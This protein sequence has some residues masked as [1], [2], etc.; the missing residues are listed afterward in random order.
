MKK[1]SKLGTATFGGGCFWGIE[2]TFR[3]T[4][5]VIDTAV[6]YMGGSTKNPTYDDVCTDE[7]GHVEVVQITFDPSKITYNQLLDVFWKS[8]DL[9]QVN[10]QGP[11]VDSQ[12]RSVIFF[13][14]KEQEEQAKNS[15]LAIEKSDRFKKAIATVILPAQRF[16][17]AEECHQKYL[18]K[19]GVKTCHL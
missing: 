19:K 8:H 18:M 1:S 10:R 7:T 16:Y 5:G 2:E 6:G 3:T 13:H 15:K 9:T 17:K 12:Y 14:S 11:D 4:P